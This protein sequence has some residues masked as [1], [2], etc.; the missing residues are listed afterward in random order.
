MDW[1]KGRVYLP[2]E[3]LRRFGVSEA[4]IA[5]G[6]FN[7]QFRE[8]M[9]FEVERA[10]HW[11]EL[12]L[13]LVKMV[14]RSLA[15]DLELFSRGGLAILEAIEKQGYNVLARRPSLSK[16]RKAG[17]VLRAVAGRIA[18]GRARDEHDHCNTPRCG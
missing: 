11:F 13:P 8:L 18:L 16:F 5:E 15:L 4:Q 9:R 10:R 6:S 17:L 14:N 3:D 12:G 7:G 1:K 2:L